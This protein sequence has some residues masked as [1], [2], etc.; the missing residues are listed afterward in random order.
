MKN[1]MYFQFQ[2]FEFDKSYLV[3]QVTCSSF[4]RNISVLNFLS[5]IL[6]LK[7]ISFY[8]FFAK[9]LRP[10]SDL[11]NNEVNSSVVARTLVG[12]AIF[13]AFLRGSPIVKP[14][15]LLVK[16]LFLDS[17]RLLVGNDFIISKIYTMSEK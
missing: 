9:K 16:L 7:C 3:T 6:M 4:I 15:S 8:C 17:I 14:V 11:I 10:R 5:S 12:V 1:I 13:M 2:G